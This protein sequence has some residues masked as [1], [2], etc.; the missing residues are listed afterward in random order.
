MG[1]ESKKPDLQYLYI[2]KSSGS[3]YIKIREQ[4]SAEW[5][6]VNRIKV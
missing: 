6:V 1:T 4:R 5:K 3:L 2:T